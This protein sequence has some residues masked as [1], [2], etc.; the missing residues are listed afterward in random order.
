M[1]LIEV[2]V[3]MII[4]TIIS[5]IAY[6]FYQKFILGLE[7]QKKVTSLQ[8]GIRN[9]SECINRY[10]MAGGVSGDSLFFDPHKKLSATIVN[11]GHR[12]FDFNSDSTMLT[13]YGNFSGSAASLASPVV[14]KAIRFVKTDKA[15]LFKAGGY[16][17]IYAG[18]AQEVAHILSISD[19][20]LNFANDF[21][22]PYPKGTLIFPL[23]RVTISLPDSKTLRI[24]RESPNGA[25]NFVRD[26]TPTEH[27]SD[28]LAFK[29]K[30][31]DKAAGQ[32]S[33]ALTFTVKTGSPPQ[34]RLTRQSDQ[35][36]F[37]RGF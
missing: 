29:V 2:M 4:S 16:A 1:T 20:T 8:E 21:F 24:S 22:A 26:F 36:V 30:T 35:T 31:V 14:D 23:E 25:A 9:A 37:V 32:I 3:A 6:R 10:L 28:S 17:Y 5:L 27:F 7:Q 19:S 13:V 12:V 33:Y 11:G 18:S 15:S 34:M